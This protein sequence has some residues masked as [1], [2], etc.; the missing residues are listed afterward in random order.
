MSRRTA[1]PTSICLVVGVALLAGPGLA[2]TPAP[3][4]SPSPGRPGGE[5]LRL[6][7]PG[8]EN[9][10]APFGITFQSL[11]TQDILNLV[12]DTLLYSPNQEKP[13]PWLASEASKSSDG[14]VW[15]FKIRPGIT[16]HDGRPVTAEDVKFTYEYFFKHQQGRYSHHVNDLPYVEKAELVGSD[17]VSFTCRTPCPTFDIDPGSDLPVI[18]KHIWESVTEPTKFTK[19]LPVGSGPYRVV[20]HTSEQSYRLKANERYFKGKPLVDEIQMPIIKESATMFLALRTGQVDSVSRVVPPESIAELERTGITVVRMPDYGSVQMNFNAQRP[21]LTQPKL[22]KAMNLAVDTDGITKTLLFDTGKPGVESFLDP[23][24]PFA[25]RSLKHEYS[26]RKARALLDEIDFTD[27][28]GDGI[29]ETPEGKPLD[30]EVLV[31]SI[32]AREVR[33]CELVAAQLKEVGVNLRVNPTDPVTLNSRRQP[34][35]AASKK[36]PETTQTGDYDLYV[37]AYVGGHFHFDPD[38]LLYPFHSPGKTGFGAFI[39]GWSNPQFDELV[40]RA[41]QLGVDERKPL[42]IQAQKVMF[43]DPPIIS[44]YFP[45][46]AFAYRPQAFSGWVRET[47]HGIFHKRSFLPGKRGEAVPV[48]KTP[49]EK[50]SVVLPAVI[51]VLV[52]L[53]GGMV[54]LRR[55]KSAAEQAKGPEVD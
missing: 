49:D 12:Y 22:R 40:D 51:V 31:S 32:E 30:F 36:V 9:N 4:G 48:S 14:R 50:G 46:G 8:D 17:S 27:R 13:E 15:T 52:A 20:E 55:R 53:G 33:A 44:L 37:S 1:I 26:P 38:G 35:D 39:T 16:W 43:D 21:P 34:K 5:V 3:P 29:R 11:K 19:D 6:A 25:D 45:D 47:G 41:S 2:Q 24:S 54:L 18:P 42:L 10:F 28:N 23:D 7:I